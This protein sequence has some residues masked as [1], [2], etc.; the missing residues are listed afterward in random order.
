MKKFI[1]MCSL[2]LGLLFAGVA[3]AFDYNQLA[4]CEQAAVAALNVAHYGTVIKVS[5]EFCADHNC[6]K[7]K[8]S[9]NP[10]IIHLFVPLY[11]QSIETYVTEM[12]ECLAT[13]E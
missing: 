1:A 11:E 3:S 12:S 9:G 5:G 8:F 10:K 13:L 4:P 6:T 2:A 7:K